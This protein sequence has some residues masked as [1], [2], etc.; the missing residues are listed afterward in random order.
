MHVTETV[1]YMC[2]HSP[3]TE[4]AYCPNC[5]AGPEPWQ[6]SAEYDMDDVDL[7]VIISDVHYDDDWKLWQSFCR[8]VF[9]ANIRLGADDIKNFDKYPNLPR[10]KYS[11]VDMYYVV[12][13]D[14]IAGPWLD[15]AEAEDYIN[16]E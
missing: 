2:N 15:R 6:D 4:T 9:D 12:E 11:E 3:D 1:C 10:M 7:P 13:R 16:N 14:G 8:E 5:G